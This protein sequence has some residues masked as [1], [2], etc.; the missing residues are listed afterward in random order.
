M[1]SVMDDGHA[2]HYTAVERG[3][4]V[5]GSDG[6]EVGKV[7]Q[8]V[9]NYEEHI[10]DGIVIAASDGELRFVDGPEVAR[11]AERAVTLAIAGEE[12]AKLPPP[13]RGAGTFKAN[14]RAGRLG[15][16]LGGGW[17]RQ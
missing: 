13:E 4:P 11:T 2:I 3:T 17:K 15:R 5:Y 6:V 8:V 16:L 12:A 10:L 9:D 7:D 14:V 1:L